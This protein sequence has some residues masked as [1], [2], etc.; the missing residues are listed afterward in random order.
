MVD[1]APTMPV[2]QTVLS[3]AKTE[4]DFLANPNWNPFPLFPHWMTVNTLSL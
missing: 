1:C 3:N 2:A 4:C